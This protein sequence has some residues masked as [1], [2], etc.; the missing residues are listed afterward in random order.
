MIALCTK[1][2]TLLLQHP[3]VELEV[4]F[5]KSKICLSKM[6]LRKWNNKNDRCFPSAC[7]SNTAN[8][9]NMKKTNSLK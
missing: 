7:Y 9:L 2:D 6:V 1:Y 4:I 3:V 5:M 8:T